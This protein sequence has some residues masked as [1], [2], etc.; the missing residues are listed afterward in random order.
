MRVEVRLVEL[1]PF[2]GADLYR[3]D[4]Q[5]ICEAMAEYLK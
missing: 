4:G 3:C 5:A 2:S 1:N